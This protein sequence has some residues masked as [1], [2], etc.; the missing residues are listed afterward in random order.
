MASSAMI[1]DID[2][3]NMTTL[4]ATLPPRPDGDTRESLSL[5]AAAAAAAT[6]LTVTYT[7]SSGVLS[8]TGSA[9][10]ATYQTI[11]DGIQYTNTKPGSHSTTARN[12]DVVVNDG[13]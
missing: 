7:N 4:T 2:S 3:A 13:T 9:T 5:N 1:T 8:I 12:V 10:K 6:G 11:L